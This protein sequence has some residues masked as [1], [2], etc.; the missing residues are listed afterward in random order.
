MS[1]PVTITLGPADP[2][3]CVR[4]CDDILK[5]IQSKITAVI[6]SIKGVIIQTDTP[7][8]GDRDKLWIEA[9]ASSCT[10]ENFS[11]EFKLWCPNEDAWVLIK[12]DLSQFTSGP[13][14]TLIGS[15]AGKIE[16]KTISQIIDC[17]DDGQIPCSKVDFGIVPKGCVFHTWHVDVVANADAIAAGRIEFDVA[18]TSVK[19]GSG[20]K[21]VTESPIVEGNTYTLDI[22]MPEDAGSITTSNVRGNITSPF[23]DTTDECAVE[24]CLN[25]LVNAIKVARGGPFTVPTTAGNVEADGKMIRWAHGLA[26]VPDVISVRLKCVT[27]TQGYINSPAMYVDIDRFIDHDGDFPWAVAFDETYV[28]VWKSGTSSQDEV[29]EFNEGALQLEITPVNWRMYITA[30]SYA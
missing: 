10:T 5:L 26:T 3:C 11:A 14:C 22:C 23:T 18:W 24:G 16:N 17:M 6:P 21:F 2:G 7:A 4:T 13:D 25:A 12:F 15:R 19:C 28:Y 1:I 27:N 30:T 29:I 8:I 20:R 9:D